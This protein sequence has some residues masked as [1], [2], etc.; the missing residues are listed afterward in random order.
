MKNGVKDLNMTGITRGWPEKRRKEQAQKVKKRKPWKNATGPKTAE[1]KARCAQNSTRT[2]LYNREMQ[3]IR[4]WM[5]AQRRYLK[6]VNDALKNRHCEEPK[7]R[8]TPVIEKDTGLPRDLS[9]ARNDDSD[10]ESLDKKTE[11]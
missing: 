1:G 5:R 10:P 4:A 11:I 2:G 8:S 3:E 9:V 6:S 7:R